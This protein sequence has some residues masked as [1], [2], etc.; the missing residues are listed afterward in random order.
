VEWRANFV[1][2]EVRQEAGAVT[3]G[4]RGG[5]GGHGGRMTRA[6]QIMVATWKQNLLIVYYRLQSYH[7]IP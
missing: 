6:G 4:G 7:P 3:E 1:G 2:V 5:G